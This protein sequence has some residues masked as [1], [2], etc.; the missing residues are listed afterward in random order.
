MCQHLERSTKHY[1]YGLHKKGY[2]SFTV[3]NGWLDRWKKRHGIH[4]L[5]M[6][7]EILSSDQTAT[8]DYKIKF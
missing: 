4:Q 8:D 2:V 7:G 5:S 6:C 3:S 1:I